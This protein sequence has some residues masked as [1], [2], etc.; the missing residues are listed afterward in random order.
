MKKRTTLLLALLLLVITSLQA[1]PPEEFKYQAVLRDANGI[2]K[3]NEDVSVT[4]NLRQGSPSGPSVFT[5]SHQITTTAQGI[6]NVNIGSVQDLSVVDWSANRYFVEITVDSTVMGSSQL[7]SVP[8][9]LHAERAASADYQDLSNKPDVPEDVS[10]LSD[11]TGLF[12]DGDYNSLTN[13]PDLAP[14]IDSTEAALWDKD[15]TNELQTL[16]ISGDTLFLSQGNYTILP[17]TSAYSENAGL[18][19]SASV[20]DRASVAD[21]ASVADSASVADRSRSSDT[22]A[23]AKS[24]QMQSDDGSTYTLQIDNSGNV[25]ANLSLNMVSV[26]GGTFVMGC[27]SEQSIC[28]DDETP[29]H[30]VTVDDFEISK[31]EITN[32]QYAEFMN[33]IGANSDGSYQ[34]TE[35]LGMDDSDCQISYSN[36]HF[37]AESGKANYP[38][39]EVTWH[40][41][42]A[43]CEHHGGRLP[44][45]AEW[46]FA[47]RGG[48]S[49]TATEYAG[50]N[51]IDEV[52]WYSDN[53][54]E[55]QLVGTKAPNE[56][57]L[58]D[59]SGNVWEW[60]NDWYG[61]EYYNN[62]PQDN[63]QGPS[64]GSGRVYR[65]GGWLND[66]RYCRVAN[67][68]S[69]S[70]S[71]SFNHLG[72]RLV[73]VP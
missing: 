61:S 24:L 58:Y 1:Q 4:I 22:S 42:K 13:T 65:G 18:A 26:S 8:Y 54:S 28:E 70:P 12:F 71:Y 16:S 48:N 29:V 25:Y 36:G 55:T 66:A 62:S 67:R 37:H 2:V 31:Y 17:D 27:T 63:P 19:D 23:V 46:E 47:A 30:S 10:E 40:G 73:F 6:I 7:L 43:F 32:Q 49:A 44:T 9:A 53:S 56:L 45:E 3:A 57:G 51:N 41:A 69:W 38:V 39:I 60:C 5:E 33:E 11:T 68:S 64:S 50:S 34:G 20:A 59:M 14:Y 35:Y 21:T 72:F 52:A 15:T